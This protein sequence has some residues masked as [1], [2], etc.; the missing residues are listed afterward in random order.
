MSSKRIEICGNIAS[1]KTTL[2]SILGSSEYSAIY[3]KFRETQ[4]YAA[5]YQDPMRYAFEAELDFTLQH[6]HW[7]KK[8]RARG[9][10]V[11]DYSL[12]LDRA[13]A[14]AN[15]NHGKLAAFDAVW[16]EIV[17]DVGQPDVIIYLN[18]SP[19]ILVDR[20]IARSRPEESE[21]GIDY[22]TKLDSAIK[23][24]LMLLNWP[25]P[26]LQID[27]GVIDFAAGSTSAAFET[28]L[29]S[30]IARVSGHN[31]LGWYQFPG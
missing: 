24:E 4:F 30:S 27:S 2:A 13:Y 1:G 15:L 7:I 10:I 19:A 23:Q 3:E 20:I 21:I 17:A 28:E 26:V 25:V 6:Y 31:R 9:Q 22:I 5:F 18:C 8:E 29:L 16:T 12:V 14:N 11:C